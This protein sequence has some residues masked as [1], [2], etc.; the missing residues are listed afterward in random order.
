MKTSHIMMYGDII[1]V[2]SE[3]HTNTQWSTVYN[4]WLFLHGST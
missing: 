3:L 2:C 4:F 1:A